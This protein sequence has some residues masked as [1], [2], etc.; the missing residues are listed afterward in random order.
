MYTEYGK[1]FGGSCAGVTAAVTASAGLQEP[2]E[3]H[4][5]TVITCFDREFLNYY[6]GE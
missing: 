2:G 6:I 1:R 3:G 5:D 4:S